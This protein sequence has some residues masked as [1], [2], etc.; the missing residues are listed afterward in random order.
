MDYLKLL[1]HSFTVGK[2]VMECP[3]ESRF[4]FLAE[5]IFGFTTYDSDMS[6]L[7]GRKA[8]EVCTAINDRKTFGYQKEGD[9]YQ[10]YLIMC[11]MPFFADKLEWGASIRG[12]WW[13][14][15]GSKMFEL[16]SCALWE[17]DH[18]I[19]TPLQF[20]E[21]QWK[22]FVAAMAIFAAVADET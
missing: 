6:D 16:S 4:E 21:E 14:L 10:W 20:N 15:H 12:A 19:L 1:E 3:P 22:S 13:D 17:N 8:V 18:Q 5:S 9:G 7:F 11:N 2:E